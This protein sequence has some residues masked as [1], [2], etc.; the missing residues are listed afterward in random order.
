MCFSLHARVPQNSPRLLS[1]FSRYRIYT[2]IIWIVLFSI[3][4][5][6]ILVLSSLS[7]FLCFL[8]LFYLIPTTLN[9]SPQCAISPTAQTANNV[10]FTVLCI[11]C[12]KPTYT[13]PFKNGGLRGLS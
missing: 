10:Y 3:D 7:F 11:A 5:A 4:I 13:A 1:L 6:V 9:L 2:F 8:I 12:D